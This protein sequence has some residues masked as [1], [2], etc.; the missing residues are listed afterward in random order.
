MLTTRAA[1]GITPMPAAGCENNLRPR[2]L[3][4]CCFVLAQAPTLRHGPNTLYCSTFAASGRT[5]SASRRSPADR[6][7]TG[8][9]RRC[10]H[11]QLDRSKAFCVHCSRHLILT[12]NTPA[13]R[14]NEHTS[15]GMTRPHWL[16][17]S[18][19]GLERRDEAGEASFGTSA[20]RTG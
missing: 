3:P 1:A 19:V 13:N 6:R 14:I 7:R 15:E 12:R 20:R 4:R 8:S 18:N 9:P 16:V 11:A 10:M 5:C 17:G 2:D